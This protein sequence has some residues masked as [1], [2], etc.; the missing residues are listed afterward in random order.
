MTIVA[1]ILKSK[2]DPAVHTT[3]SAA[4]VFDAIGLMFIMLIQP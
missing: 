1:E 4:S 2:A 3:G